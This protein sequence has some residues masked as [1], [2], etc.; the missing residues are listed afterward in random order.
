MSNTTTPRG[1]TE[2]RIDQLE[3]RVSALERALERERD[4]DDSV[5]KEYYTLEEVTEK[6]DVPYSLLTGTPETD[7]DE[8]LQV[9]GVHLDYH[10]EMLIEDYHDKKN[11]VDEHWRVGRWDAIDD[12]QN[13]IM[14]LGEQWEGADE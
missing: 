4:N 13:T 7:L 8:L 5:T 14:D 2:E 11:F 9:V 1:Q 6:Y 3:Q 10:R 12:V